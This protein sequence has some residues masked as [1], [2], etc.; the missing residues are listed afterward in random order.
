MNRRA[1]LQ[2]IAAGMAAPVVPGRKVYSFL[3]DNPLVVTIADRLVSAATLQAS[4]GLPNGWVLCV[5]GVPVRPRQLFLQGDMLTLRSAAAFR[6]SGAH[7]RAA[8]RSPAP[9]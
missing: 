8:A 1:F 6:V 3:W 9:T 5:N 7:P 4:L 2:A